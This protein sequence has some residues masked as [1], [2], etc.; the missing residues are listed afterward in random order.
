MDLNFA[1]GV[2]TGR[3]DPAQL[4]YWSSFKNWVRLLEEDA[5]LAS[6]IMIQSI[7]I[8]AVC[9]GSDGSFNSMAFDYDGTI[10]GEE[11]SGEVFVQND[12]VAILIVLDDGDE[13][14]TILSRQPRVAI[15][16]GNFREIPSGR[17]SESGQF[18]GEATAALKE[19]AGITMNR[20][21]LLNM[22][23][24]AYGNEFRGVSTSPGRSNDVAVLYLYRKRV[25][26]YDIEEIRRATPALRHEPAKTDITVAKLEDLWMCSADAT[27]LC[28]VLLYKKLLENG[29]IPPRG[30][31][32]DT[33]ESSSPSRARRISSQNRLRFSFRSRSPG[34]SS[35]NGLLPSSPGA[36]TS[37]KSATK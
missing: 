7:C 1:E 32:T 15:G 4:F 22:T 16:S 36:S 3:F 21:G 28:A 13:E 33:S 5:T 17:F 31:L 12:V 9:T 25:T 8:R 19:K 20:S 23:S 26:K 6:P 29:F 37:P 14:Y 10:Q 11:V 34:S 35:F 30:S 24:A 2:L 27:S 18:E